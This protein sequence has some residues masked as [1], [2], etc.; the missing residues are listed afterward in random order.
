M[1]FDGTYLEL[2]ISR[3]IT[4]GDYIFLI[5]GIAPATSHQ[6]KPCPAE[7]MRYIIQEAR[8]RFPDEQVLQRMMAADGQGRWCESGEIHLLATR[9]LEEHKGDKT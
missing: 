3:E 2:M 5:A 9:W 1:I 7:P 4:V 6:G 8:R